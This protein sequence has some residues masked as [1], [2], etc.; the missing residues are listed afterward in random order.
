MLESIEKLNWIRFTTTLVFIWNLYSFD[1]SI[2]LSKM[3]DSRIF[4][5]FC[6]RNRDEQHTAKIYEMDFFFVRHCR[7]HSTQPHRFW[8]AQLRTQA[9][10]IFL[11]RSRSLSF[12]R[13]QLYSHTT[14]SLTHTIAAQTQ[15]SEIQQVNLFSSLLILHSCDNKISR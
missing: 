14:A 8:H 13:S 3:C 2:F 9:A 15:Q 12:T 1:F 10:R 5:C 6:T 11:Y 4:F 7:M